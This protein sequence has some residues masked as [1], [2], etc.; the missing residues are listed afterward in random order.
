ME[1][2]SVLV[3]EDRPSVLKV[4]V[5]IL[6]GAYQVSTAA[7]GGTALSLLQSGT[8]DVL[9]TDVRLPGATG[10]DVLREVRSVSPGTSVVM[11][12]AY[13][14]IPDAVSAMRM[15]AYDYVAK[16]LDADEIKLV[17]ARA[18]ARARGATSLEA[19]AGGE[20]AAPLITNPPQDIAR[21]YHSA[22]EEARQRAS[23][24]YLVELLRLSEGNVTRAA[25]LG[26]LTRESLH[27]LMR[28]YGLRAS[29]PA[30]PGSEGDSEDSVHEGPDAEPS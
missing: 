19:P 23:R 21:G 2:P 10:F 15:G 16:P 29:T 12:T 5:A 7:D 22:I 14:N 8:F 9:L 26:G 11:M 24:A 4:M 1:K 6:E 30:R 28:K 18:A 20:D 17:V 13:A 3:V 25:T 27:R